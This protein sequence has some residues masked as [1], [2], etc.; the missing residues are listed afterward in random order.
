MIIIVKQLKII[1]KNMNIYLH[2]CTKSHILDNLF[3]NIWTIKYFYSKLYVNTLIF[4][5]NILN[6]YFN[7]LYSGRLNENTFKMYLK[8]FLWSLVWRK[9]GKVRI[10]LWAY[11][12]QCFITT[13]NKNRVLKQ[14][15]MTKNKIFINISI[16]VN[17]GQSLKLCSYIL[18]DNSG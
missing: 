16:N 7:I 12:I 17:H 14:K 3:N 1:S 2:I 4:S 10:V 5:R 6:I 9:D 18:I 8:H 13:L 11:F 15:S